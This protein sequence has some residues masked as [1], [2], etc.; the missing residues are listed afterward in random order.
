MRSISRKVCKGSRL[1]KTNIVP[2]HD[3]QTDRQ[4]KSQHVALEGTR[5][6]RP[7]HSTLRSLI[8]DMFCT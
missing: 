7:N 6:A 2:V 3:T 8:V 1:Q 4:T 5:F